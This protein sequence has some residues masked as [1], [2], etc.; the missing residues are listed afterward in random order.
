MALVSRMPNGGGMVPDNS[1]RNRL[2][3]G[4][5][6]NSAEEELGLA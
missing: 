1:R 5:H 6:S 3:S 4:H 2:E